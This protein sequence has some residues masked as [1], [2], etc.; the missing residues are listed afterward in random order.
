MTYYLALYI[1]AG[2][3]WLLFRIAA[4]FV[5]WLDRIIGETAR[6]RVFSYATAASYLLAGLIYLVAVAVMLWPVSVVRIY[7][8]WRAAK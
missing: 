5:G 2:V 8:K 4:D 1:A 6:L 3:T 7:R